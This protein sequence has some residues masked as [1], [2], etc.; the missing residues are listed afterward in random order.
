MYDPPVRLTRA[1]PGA[2]GRSKQHPSDF[3]VEELPAYEPC[4]EGDHVWFEVRK[5]GLTTPDA[6]AL[7]AQALG[8]G[9]RAIG[10]AG[11]KDARA[12]TRQWMSLEHVDPERVAS[13]HHPKLEVLRVT[14]HG[15]KLRLG[16]LR[17]NRFAIRLREVPPEDLP[18]IETVLAVLAARGVPN[19]FGEQRFGARGDGWRV[20]RALLRDDPA[21]AVALLCGR[22]SEADTGP[23]RR[24]RELFDAGDYEG[25]ARTWPR[26]F[27][28]SARVARAMARGRGRPA[29]ALRALP[30]R[31][32]RLLV[33]AFQSHLFN[34][35]LGERIDGID[36]VLA[37]D[38]A[39]RHAGG[40][41]FRVAD[42]GVEQSRARTF[43]ISATGPLFGRRMSRADGE[44]G[45][46]EARVEAE[47]LPGD[48]LA[49]RGPLAWKGARRPLRVPLADLAVES[50]EDEHGPYCELR[51]ALPAG[52][53][54]TAVLAEVLRD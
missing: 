8:V 5:S 15:N 9:P 3:R 11:L 12:V 17:G 41:V 7:V 49:R 28:D 1:L 19:Y 10:F 14:R 27:G 6:V 36:A 16:H 39:Y 44:P 52:S 25:S 33:S 30:R 20:G 38:L 32:Q 42:P 54:A 34:R 13:F 4:G 51:F 24:A 45:A 40:A 43:E 46:I 2:R 31:L 29:R 47:E 22:P 37:G 23:V 21:E 26:G 50:G 53:Y 18:H 48:E 35:V